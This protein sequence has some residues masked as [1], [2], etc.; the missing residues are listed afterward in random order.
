V[1]IK[2][3]MRTRTSTIRRLDFF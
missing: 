1:K 3:G 2:K